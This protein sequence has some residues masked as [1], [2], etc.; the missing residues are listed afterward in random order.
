MSKFAHKFV[1]VIIKYIHERF[2]GRET[3]IYRKSFIE[4]A[5]LLKDI[6]RLTKLHITRY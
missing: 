6:F 3:Y 1:N 5:Y 2:S 4:S